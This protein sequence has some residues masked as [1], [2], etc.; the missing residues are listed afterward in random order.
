MLGLE[1]LSILR[2][3]GGD[4]IRRLDQGALEPH[5]ASG[6]D[7]LDHPVQRAGIVVDALERELGFPVVGDV[8]QLRAPPR[9]PATPDDRAERPGVRQA[10]EH[11]GIP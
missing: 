2:R 11:D 10:V 8:D 5:D 6:I 7:P 4:E 3:I 1:L 9:A